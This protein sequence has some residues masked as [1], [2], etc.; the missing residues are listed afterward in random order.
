MLGFLKSI[1]WKAPRVP[2]REKWGLDR[3]PHHAEA[4]KHLQAGNLVEGERSL[5][6][7]LA[8]AEQRALAPGLRVVLRLD[9][10]EVQRRLGQL[11]E[12]ESTL[13]QAAVL[14]VQNSDTEQFL[15]CLDALAEVYSAM[16]NF[17]ALEEVV[18]EAIHLSATVPGEDAW[19][20][21]VR[22]RR[23][24]LA[25]DKNG[26]FGE[27]L[28]TFDKA[29]AL[30]E[31]SNGARHQETGD[32]V[33]EAGKLC[34]QH[35]EHAKAQEYLRRALRIHEAACGADSAQAFN[36]VKELAGSLEES[37]DQQGAAA[38]YERALTLKLRK[39]GVGN[40]DE[41]AEMQ[42]SLAAL[43]TGWGNL[44]RAREL[45]EDAI[46]EFKRSKG[47]R[48]AVAYETLADIEER[49]GR[50][51][52]AVT[53]LGKAAQ[54]WEK[55]GSERRQELAQNLLYQAGLL[56]QLRQRREANY[57]RRR[58]EDLLA[59]PGEGNPEARSA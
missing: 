58:A 38:Q 55:C 24:A 39:L 17:P 15:D 10:A 22:V 16:E 8:D 59:D 29:I 46:G 47:P 25:Q 6:A 40:L 48:L 52:F 28:A 18:L 56:E 9:L 33:A 20:K 35:G 21:E 37:G 49:S 54:V 31:Q 5:A 19:R 43:Y 30:R 3:N 50:V 32:L 2:Q 41:V 23:L 4:Q 7:A 26:R 45:L 57:L 27:A 34:R 12:A 51:S 1:Q 11:R 14:S 53:E 44:S 42:Y 13:R 36:D